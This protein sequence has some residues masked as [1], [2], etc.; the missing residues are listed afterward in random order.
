MGG[1]GGGGG[2]EVMVDQQ[3]NC[4]C[5]QH[6]NGVA[7]SLLW[8]SYS[9]L[10]QT[11][12]RGQLK[13]LSFLLHSIPFP[14]HSIIPFKQCCS[15]QGPFSYQAPAAYQPQTWCI[16]L[17]VVRQHILELLSPLSLLHGNHLLA[18]FAVAWNDRRQKPNGPVKKVEKEEW[19]WCGCC[20]GSR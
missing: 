14:H 16:H 12:T 10:L 3:A 13:A 15:W 20:S 7:S 2:V 6:L 4:L 17:Q 11:L 9:L 18:A 5:C 19:R 1:W 8:L